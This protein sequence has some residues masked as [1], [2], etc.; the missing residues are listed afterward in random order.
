MLA[1]QR[2][3]PNSLL[4]WLRQQSPTF[5][6]AAAVLA[7]HLIVALSGPLWA[8]YAPTKMLVGAP[9]A[10]PS[11]EHW[12]GTDNFGRDVFSRLVHGERV[13]LVLAFSATGLAVIAGSALGL[14]TAYARGWPDEAVMRVVE[15]LLSIPPLILAL[16]ILGA[17]GS[18]YVVVVLTV[19][20]FFT[21]RVA[22]VVRAAAL[23]VVTEDF[24]T[25]AR[26][27]GES[28]WSIAVREL[29][30]NVMSSVLVELSLRTGYAVLFIG[31]L[32]FLGF[33]SAPPTPEWGL[34]INEGRTYITAAPWMVL[35]PSLALA[36]LVVAL[37][38]FTEGISEM[39]GLSARRERNA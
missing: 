23:G 24:I 34:M 19:A 14:I 36:S 16:L 22:T 38:L 37:S 18:N 15:I 17:L 31:G 28:A 8:P 26:L 30:P 1:R 21:P 25:L 13:V 6:I 4:G 2:P 9:F 29:L 32:S 35:T 11:I 10:P 33:G 7:L 12:L 5:L 20:F 3:W 27:R 39:L